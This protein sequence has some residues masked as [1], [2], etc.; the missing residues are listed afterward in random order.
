MKKK[1]RKHPQKIVSEQVYTQL[2]YNF[3]EVKR[4][5]HATRIN[6]FNIYL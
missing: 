1:M 5:T 4:D 3:Y 6:I 2:Y